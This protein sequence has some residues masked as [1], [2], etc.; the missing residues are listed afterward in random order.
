MWLTVTGCDWVVWLSDWVLLSV[1][2]CDWVVWLSD[3]VLLGV[4]LGV[5]LSVTRCDWVLL[6][7]TG[8]YWVWLGVSGC[9]SNHW[10][11]R[12]QLRL[13]ATSVTGCVWVWLRCDKSTYCTDHCATTRGP[14]VMYQWRL[15]VG[16]T[17]PRDTFTDMPNLGTV[18]PGKSPLPL[19]VALVYCKLVALHKLDIVCSCAVMSYRIISQIDSAA[20]TKRT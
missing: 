6:S 8:C 5:S 14:V 2:G 7:V 11:C 17:S 13:G 20:I 3:W 18:I 9:D 1:T 4:Y 10:R 16:G 12:L 19:C 15:F